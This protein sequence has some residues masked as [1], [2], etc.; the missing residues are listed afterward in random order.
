MTFIDVTLYS[1]IA[2]MYNLFVHNLASMSY[3]DLQYD[4]KYENTLIMIVI[5]GISGIIISKC[6]IDKNKEYKNSLVSKGLY[7]GGIMLILTALF[8]NWENMTEEL[9]LL[10][11]AGV[12]VYLLWY[13]RKRDN[14]NVIKKEEE[15]KI[16]EEI[17]NEIVKNDD[18]DYTKKIEKGRQKIMNI[19][20]QH[21]LNKQDMNPENQSS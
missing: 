16:N 17:I 6:V 10:L 13:S 2:I 4:D 15:G 21:N 11:I 8:V 1:S 12:F 9:K 19:Q 14:Y 20:N 3:R 7:Y 5:F 18:D